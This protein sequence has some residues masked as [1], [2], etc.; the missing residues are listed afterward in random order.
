LISEELWMRNMTIH[1]RDQDKDLIQTA[2]A[3]E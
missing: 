1:G 3:L 2:I